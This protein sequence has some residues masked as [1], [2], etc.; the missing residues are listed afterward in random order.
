MGGESKNKDIK[1]KKITNK[2]QRKRVDMDDRV[3][4][5]LAEALE[6]VPYQ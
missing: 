3:R 4:E 6:S 5:R 2:Q 1:K